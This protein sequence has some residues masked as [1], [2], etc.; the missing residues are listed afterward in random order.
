LSWERGGIVTL[1]PKQSIGGDQ[2]I[3]DH[4]LPVPS[5]RLSTGELIFEAQHVPALG[6]RYYKVVAGKA[7]A[8]AGMVVTSTALSNNFISVQIDTT[9]GRI[10]SAKSLTNGYE[11]VDA[12][13]GLNAYQYVTGVHNGKD[14]PHKPTTNSNVSVGVK[15]K[16]PLLVSLTVKSIADGLKSLTS[17][18]CLYRNAP[19]IKV[20]NIL[21]KISTRTKEAVHFGFGFNVPNSTNRIEM[22]W[23]IVRPNTDQLARANKNWFAFQRWVDISND[24]CGVT[25]SAIEAPLIEWGALSGYILDGARLAGL[26][27]K[28]APQSATLYSWP[29]NNHWDTNFPLEQGGIIKQTYVVTFHNKY[30]VVAANRFG[31]ETHRP[32]IVV[33]A[34]KNIIEKPLFSISNPKLVISTL[35]RTADNK[36]LLLRVKSVSDKV[37]QLRLDWP[38]ARPKQMIACNADETPKEKNDNSIEI[39][40]YGMASVRLVF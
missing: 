19:L 34:K 4:N 40:P 1:T 30:D 38:G 12:K 39:A 5:Q 20:V 18:I 23:S 9:T 8:A 11:Y 22:P 10:S 17:E 13:V 26:W 37:E 32:L 6:S 15:E 35:Q 7:T 2:V 14:Y 33:Q 36:G 31:L 29:L 3:D 27:Q 21:D 16:G 24:S 25:W 28:E